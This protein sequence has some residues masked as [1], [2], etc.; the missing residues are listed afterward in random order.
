MT[1][2]G[3]AAF[4]LRSEKRSGVYGHERETP[5]ELPPDWRSR[6]QTKKRAWLFFESQAPS[7][8]RVALHWVMNAKQEATRA[9]RFEQ[10][11]EDSEAQQRVGPLRRNPK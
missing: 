9:R 6:F 8:R 5:A 4:A 3:R 7:Y 10:L 11:L 2:A 1:D